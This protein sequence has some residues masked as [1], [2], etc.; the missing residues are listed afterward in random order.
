MAVACFDRATDAAIGFVAYRA[1]SLFKPTICLHG[2]LR[3]GWGIRLVQSCVCLN[4]CPCVVHRAVVDS[5]NPVDVF[6]NCID[7]STD[8]SCFVVRWDNHTNSV[9][10]IHPHPSG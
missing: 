7:D 6:R 9:P 10:S 2:L 3:I 5:V 4:F 8:K 1:D